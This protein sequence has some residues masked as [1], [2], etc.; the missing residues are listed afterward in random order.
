MSEYEH[1][2]GDHGNFLLGAKSC[3]RGNYVCV[4]EA[5]EPLSIKPK[6]YG[7][8]LHTVSALCSGD[9]ALHG[10]PPYKTDFS[11]LSCVVCSK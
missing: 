9:K 3:G 11:A 5:S 4:D 2:E 1:L 10:C 7:G 8:V 6:T